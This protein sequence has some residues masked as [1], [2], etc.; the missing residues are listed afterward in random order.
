[1]RRMTP[2]GTLSVHVD[3]PG[4]YV[5]PRL[6]SLQ[7]RVDPLFLLLRKRSSSNRPS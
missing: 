3:F 4:D 6:V 1:M 2:T 7:D 5:R